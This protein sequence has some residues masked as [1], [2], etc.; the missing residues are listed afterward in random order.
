MNR[1]GFPLIELTVILLIVFFVPI[2]VIGL[3]GWTGRSLDWSLTQ[4]KHHAVHVPYWLDLIIVF[5]GDGLTFVFDVIIEIL[6]R[7]Q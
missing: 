4:W 3:T 1:K 7:V 6:R 5:I 2:I